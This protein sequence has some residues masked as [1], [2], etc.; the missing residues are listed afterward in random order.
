MTVK[1]EGVIEGGKRRETNEMTP[2][3]VR[4]LSDSETEASDERIVFGGVRV[5]ECDWRRKCDGV[6]IR[7]TQYFPNM[8]AST[9]LHL[10]CIFTRSELYTKYSYLVCQHY[11]NHK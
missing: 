10:R 1:Q 8:C 5:E 7:D 6:L 11:Q 9:F 4:N 2:L 3:K